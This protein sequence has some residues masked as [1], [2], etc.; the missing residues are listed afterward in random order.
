MITKPYSELLHQWQSDHTISH[1]LGDALTL[2]SLSSGI[3]GAADYLSLP[4]NVTYAEND[5]PRMYMIHSVSS[6]CFSRAIVLLCSSGAD[7]KNEYLLWARFLAENTGKPVLLIMHD[8][9]QASDSVSQF[10]RFMRFMNL[11]SLQTFITGTGLF[12]DD[13]VFDFFVSGVGVPV[14]R[15]YCESGISNAFSR[16]KVVFL[17]DDNSQHFD[18]LNDIPQELVPYLSAANI[19]ACSC[20]FLLKINS[21]LSQPQFMSRREPS[22]PQSSCIN[23]FAGYTISNSNFFPVINPTYTDDLFSRVITMA[24]WYLCGI[25]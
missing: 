14:V 20:Y 9:N 11:L 13:P 15:Y 3:A 18:L 16:S 4:V 8:S 2:T 23:L 6:H 5:S 12:S 10:K 21:G 19:P 25:N 1:L 22:T 17:E 7:D 24:S